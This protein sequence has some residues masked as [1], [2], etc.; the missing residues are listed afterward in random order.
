MRAI[1]WRENLLS[2]ITILDMPRINTVFASGAADNNHLDASSVRSPHSPSRTLS[3]SGPLPDLPARRATVSTGQPRNSVRRSK[4]RLNDDVINDIIPHASGLAERLRLCEANPVSIPQ[5]TRSIKDSEQSDIIDRV[6]RTLCLPNSYSILDPHVRAQ[7]RATAADNKQLSARLTDVLFNLDL[8]PAG[9]FRDNLSILFE[10]CPHLEFRS[11]R[12]PMNIILPLLGRALESDL[13]HTRTVGLQLRSLDA[14]SQEKKPGIRGIPLQYGERE[15]FF[16]LDFSPIDQVLNKLKRNGKPDLKI[17]VSLCMKRREDK[18]DT[19]CDGHKAIN[20]FSSRILQRSGQDYGYMYGKMGGDS[21]WHVEDGEVDNFIAALGD[22][23]NGIRQLHMG[24]V[25]FA[26]EENVLN[27]LIRALE[28]NTSLRSLRLPATRVSDLQFNKLFQL[29]R[30][31]ELEISIPEIKNP[32]EI[33]PF[34]KV[35]AGCRGLKTLRI[36]NRSFLEYGCEFDCPEGGATIINHIIEYA[37]KSKS[38]TCLDFS[39]YTYSRW[40]R[41][42][43][44][45]IYMLNRTTGEFQEVERDCAP[46]AHGRGKMEMT[47]EEQRANG[48]TQQAWLKSTYGTETTAL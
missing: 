34:L 29:P 8:D 17:D 5:V 13:V 23:H 48:R 38:L 39:R 6:G 32:M 43:Y 16:E 25:V 44:G 24:Q 46:D 40:H 18:F 21:L 37:A 26:D 36:A 27:R 42:V 2:F 20:W 4:V 9:R 14:V 31:E 30:L 28:N 22:R 1:I 3:T 45:P 47:S 7:I 11:N 10:L 35:I 41:D 19:N 15:E 33:R 12:H